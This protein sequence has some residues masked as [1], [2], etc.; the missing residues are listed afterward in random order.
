MQ[1]GGGQPQRRQR[2]CRKQA[3]V[4]QVV[5]REHRGRRVAACPGKRAH[6]GGGQAG[7]PVVAVND[8]GHPVRVQALPEQ[9]GRPAQR[10]KALRV[11][12]P[13]STVRPEVGV[14]GA[15]KQLRRIQ[16][17]QRQRQARQG[18][19]IQ[20]GRGQRRCGAPRCGASGQGRH[21]APVRGGLRH[22]RKAG[23]Q[24]PNIAAQRLQGRRQAGADIGQPAGLEERKQLG[25]HIQNLHASAPPKAATMALVTSTTPAGL[26]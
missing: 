3:L 1:V 6:I 11:V 8:V 4:S 14:A 16:R 9:G 10:R 12:G 20:G 18:Q 19:P 21:Q 2:R 23:H 25:T 22:R 15:V 17:V 13:V 5:H 26:R 7:M 24:E